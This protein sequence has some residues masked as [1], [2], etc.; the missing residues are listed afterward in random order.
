MK[1]EEWRIK[2]EELGIKNEELGIKRLKQIKHLKRMR[3]E[4]SSPYYIY[5]SVKKCVK[6]FLFQ[7]FSLN[8]QH[9][10]NLIGK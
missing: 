8:L 7:T 2:N 9:V 10:I 1:N 4:M 6:D 3:D 5:I